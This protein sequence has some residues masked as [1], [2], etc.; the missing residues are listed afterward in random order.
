MA[1]DLT[2]DFDVVIE[3][4]IK[5][6]DRVLAAMHRGEQFPHSLTLRVDDTSE[7][8]QLKFGRVAV[9]MVDKLG[10]ASLKHPPVAT[11]AIV[12]QVDRPRWP[13]VPRTASWGGPEVIVNDRPIGIHLA[14]EFSHLR[15]IAQLQ[16]PA[17]TID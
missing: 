14:Q 10:L 8:Q 15:G 7:G 11:P 6:T 12:G 1:N 17:P 2:G 16:L 13:I 3:F 4:T 9:S 5:A